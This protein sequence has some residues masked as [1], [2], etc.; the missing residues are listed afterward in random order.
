MAHTKGVVLTDVVIDIF[1]KG[2]IDWDDGS[3]TIAAGNQ[4]EAVKIPMSMLGQRKSA[5]QFRLPNDCVVEKDGQT[6]VI[7]R[8]GQSVVIP[9][10]LI[11]E[12]PI[13]AKAMLHS[14]TLVAARK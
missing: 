1:F 10:D 12:I 13:S 2:E 4:S 9:I 6:F 3:Y 14:P 7:R 5:T 11:G 8:A